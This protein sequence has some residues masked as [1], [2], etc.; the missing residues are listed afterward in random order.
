[1]CEVD[2]VE[3][4]LMYGCV[5]WWYVWIDGVCGGNDVCVVGWVVGIGWCFGEYGWCGF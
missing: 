4:D 3:Y 2:D 1:M 5:V